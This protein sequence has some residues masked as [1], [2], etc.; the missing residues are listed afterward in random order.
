[1]KRLIPNYKLDDF[2]AKVDSILSRDSAF[3]GPIEQRTVIRT[4]RDGNHNALT[5]I[6]I[7]PAQEIPSE[8]RYLEYGEFILIQ[9]F[10]DLTAMK[11]RL[12]LLK[13][14]MFLAGKL[15]VSLGPT[16]LSYSD[17]FR[18]S[19]NS[20]SEWP[21]MLFQI[22]GNRVQIA[23]GTLLG[24]T[25]DLR[26]YKD[27]AAAIQD[28]TGIRPFSGDSDAR[29]G[30]ILLFVPSLK[31]R[32]ERI[33][34]DH[35][36]VVVALSTDLPFKELSLNLI[37]SAGEQ[38]ASLNVEPNE[39]TRFP[40]GFVPQELELWLTS[41]SRGT[42]DFYRE[43]PHFRVGEQRGPVLANMKEVRRQRHPAKDPIPTK[44]QEVSQELEYW[45]TRLGEGLPGSTWEH[46]VET[47]LR[48]LQSRNES[49]VRGLPVLPKQSEEASGYEDHLKNLHP[50]IHAKCA[51]L[52]E[53]GHY[54]EAVEKS[55]KVVRDRLRQLTGFETGSEAFGK[56]R[57]YIKGAAAPN[58]DDDF[59]HGVKFL[60]MAIDR[61]RN[62]KSHTSDGNIQDRHRAFE[63]LVVS[64]LAMNLLE[65]ASVPD[66]TPH[67]T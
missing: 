4:D 8:A 30:S 47:R 32:I 57:L 52:F 49:L 37:A 27:A 12:Q 67:R 55:F 63:Y 24:K 16:D 66:Q 21:G 29:L 44:L 34:L 62:E 38:T 45:H 6:R 41:E 60:T 3:F 18:P 19:F 53:Q 2:L 58:V 23:S 5:L 1:M 10:M 15:S 9:E 42:L 40:I 35:G 31:A 11:E 59:N 36:D 56:G 64:S 22:A 28:F 39:T 33:Q 51:L 43:S 54:S 65:R 14:R 48:K 46:F 25:K 26:P 50:G 13:S 61:F 17:E 20:I 7:M